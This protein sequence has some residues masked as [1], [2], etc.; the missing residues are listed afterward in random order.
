[1]AKNYYQVD[2]R[3][4]LIEG[5]KEKRDVVIIESESELNNNDLAEVI[6]NN[7]LCP[8]L[9]ETIQFNPFTLRIVEARKVDVSRKCRV[10]GCDALHACEEG[11]Y[12]VA[13]DLCSKCAEKMEDGH[14][15]QI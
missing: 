9:P 12:W 13:E 3:Y 8:H 2:F 5:Q 14:G 10:C 6:K 1:M 7:Y 4:R 11:C 15:S